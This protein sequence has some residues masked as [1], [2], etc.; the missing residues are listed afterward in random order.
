MLWGIAYAHGYHEVLVAF[1]TERLFDGVVGCRHAFHHV[2][3]LHGA[4]EVDVLCHGTGIEGGEAHLVFLEHLC[5]R[6]VRHVEGILVIYY[7]K[8]EGGL[9]G[10]VLYPRVGTVVTFGDGFQRV[11][12]GLVTVNSL[13]GNGINEAMMLGA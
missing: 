6:F 2:E 7:H 5:C 10:K 1:E 8:V 12:G 9:A 4:V 3:S 13:C 11:G